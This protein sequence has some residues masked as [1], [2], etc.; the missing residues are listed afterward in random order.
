MGLIGRPTGP[1]PNSWLWTSVWV[2]VPN[3]K[4]Q[5]R[6]CMQKIRRHRTDVIFSFCD[7]FHLALLL[8]VIS[9]SA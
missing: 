5:L 1:T 3:L 8:A 4:S 9:F 2:S 7:E 6:H